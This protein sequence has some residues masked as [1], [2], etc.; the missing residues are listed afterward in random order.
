M[1]SS[2]SSSSSWVQEE[3]PTTD[4]SV[5]KFDLPATDVELVNQVFD[6]I[7]KSDQEEFNHG[8]ML[9][10]MARKYRFAGYIGAIQYLFSEIA[11]LNEEMKQMKNAMQYLHHRLEQPRTWW[12]WFYNNSKQKHV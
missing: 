6:F 5:I 12:D 7:D 4:T 9:L 3:E 11:S 10:K 1:E 2:S 8:Q